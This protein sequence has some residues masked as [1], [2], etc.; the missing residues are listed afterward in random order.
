MEE[1]SFSRR[2][3]LCAALHPIAKQHGSLV[4]WT[5]HRI[6]GIRLKKNP[7]CYGLKSTSS[8]GAAKP[9]Y[10]IRC[11]RKSRYRPHIV[12]RDPRNERSPSFGGLSSEQIVV[13]ARSKEQGA[14]TQRAKSKEL[15]YDGRVRLEGTTDGPCSVGLQQR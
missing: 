5:V 7:F 11:S 2:S 6:Q 10:K 9:A 1:F 14:K 8:A 12:N 3:I 4:G 13:L 15:T